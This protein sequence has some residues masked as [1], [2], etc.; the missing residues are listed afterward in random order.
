[1]RGTE[2]VDIFKPLR[3]W[4][5]CYCSS[6][7]HMLTPYSLTTP[8]HNICTQTYPSD[9]SFSSPPWLI[10]SELSAHLSASR[11]NIFYFPDNGKDNPALYFLIWCWFQSSQNFNVYFNY[12]GISLKW[13][14]WLSKSEMHVRFCI[15]HRATGDTDTL[16]LG[17]Q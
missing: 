9:F 13:R 17:P 6:T 8:P 15:S 14:F 2:I 7:W 4:V 5:V 11:T 12:L 3:F 10:K 16:A 1:M